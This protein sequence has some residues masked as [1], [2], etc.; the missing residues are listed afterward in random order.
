MLQ[1]LQ[2]Y[3]SAEK[4]ESLLFIAVGIRDIGLVVWLWQNGHRLQSAAFPLI[5]ITLIQLVVGGTH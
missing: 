1:D 3:F 2:R 4:S 5:A